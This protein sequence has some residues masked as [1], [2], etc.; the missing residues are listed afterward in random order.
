MN[1]I[2]PQYVD[3]P[4]IKLLKEKGLDIEIDYGLQ[5]VLNHKNKPEIWQV[6]EWLRLEHNIWIE[7]RHITTFN[8]N[9]FHVIVWNYK[10]KLD[11]KTIH[12]DNDIGYKVWDTPKEAY[13]AAIDY[14]LKELI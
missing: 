8:I 1:K 14:T 9:R 3:F 10:D 13:L 2:E 6:V 12:C 5:Q 11:Y 4:T 7:C